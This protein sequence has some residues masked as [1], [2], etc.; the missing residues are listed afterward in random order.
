MITHWFPYLYL[1]QRYDCHP[2]T[3]LLLAS[4]TALAWLFLRL[5]RRPGSV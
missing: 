2:L 1:R 5:S 3:A 4:C